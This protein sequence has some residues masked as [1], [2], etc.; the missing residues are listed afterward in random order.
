MLFRSV[1]AIRTRDERVC[2]VTLADGTTLEAPIVV[3]GLDPRRTLLDLVDPEVTGPRLGWEAGAIRARGVTAKVNLALAGLPAIDGIGDDPADP[4][5]RGR[6]LV[7]P[8]MRGLELGA[9]AAR[10]GRM[11]DEPWLEA[12]IPSL[13]D[14]LLVDG[15]EQGVRHVISVL[16][17]PVP[18]DPDGGWDAHRDALAERVIARLETVAPGIGRLVVEIGRAHV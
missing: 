17:Q 11:A 6:I 14:P 13:A 9:L 10:A 1:A 5:L 8:T 3:S 7:L 4:R 15:A 2:G 18:T 12:T 16:V